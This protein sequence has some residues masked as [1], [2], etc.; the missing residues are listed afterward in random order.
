MNN[1]NG[2]SGRRQERRDTAENRL[3]GIYGDHI[4]QKRQGMVRILFQNPQGL[5]SIASGRG[6]QSLKIRKLRDTLLTHNIDV[7]GLS[8]VNKDWRLIPQKE[9][10]WTLT[11]GWFEHRRLISSINTLVAPRTSTQYGG[12]ILM[13]VN[14][15]AH[16]I[17]SM[18]EDSRKLGRWTS[19]VIRGKNQKRARIICAY[20]PCKSAGPSSTYA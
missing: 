4:K 13:A 17:V 18:E 20:C 5:G 6:G 12:T 3:N 10:M 11:D 14:K 1:P 7:V 2:P 16:S 15:L 19:M 9:T 8:E